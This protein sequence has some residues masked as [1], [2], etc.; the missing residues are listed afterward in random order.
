M[1]NKM[2]ELQHIEFFQLRPST[3]VKHIAKGLKKAFEKRQR[4]I[5]KF[6]EKVKRIKQLSGSIKL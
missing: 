5:K 3:R 2:K 6:E 1:S 4:E